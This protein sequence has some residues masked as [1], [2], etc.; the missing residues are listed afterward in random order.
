MTADP[1][2]SWR[3]TPAKQSIVDFV[4]AVTDAGSAQFVPELDRIAVFDN[5]GTLWTEQPLYAQLVFAM[6]RA[7]EMGQPKSLEE[8]HAGGIGAL[9]E[10]VKLTHGG[11]TTDEFDTACR[12][13]IASARHPRFGRP[14]TSIV[15]QPMLE[16]LTYLDGNGFSCWIFSGGG[17]DFMR[18]WTTDVYGLP[19]HRVIG[20]VGTTEFHIGDTGPELL[21]GTDIQVLNDGP[22]KP[23][24]IHQHIGQ[25]PILAGGNTDGDLQMLQWTAASPYRTLQLVVRHTDSKREYAYDTDPI[26][27][28]GTAQLLTAASDHDWTVID[29]A[30]DWSVVFPPDD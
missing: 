24:S 23:I 21:K 19:R 6:D 26:L 25:R 30:T 17:V 7:A 1:L 13:W 15:Y 11:I 2:S 5:D 4:T 28:S 22:Q 27:G 18:A 20:S 14:Y 16:L 10:L 29:M 12:R 3:A 9:I 8:L